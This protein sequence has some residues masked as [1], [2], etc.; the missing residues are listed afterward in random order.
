MDNLHQFYNPVQLLYGQQWL[1]DV[2][3]ETSSSKTET[4]SVEDLLW[5]GYRTLSDLFFTGAGLVK[6]VIKLALNGTQLFFC[7]V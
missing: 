3:M 2:W 5:S 4:K 7:D 1:S 6:G